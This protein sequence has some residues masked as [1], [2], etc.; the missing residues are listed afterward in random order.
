MPRHRP[1]PPRHRPV[2]VAS[3]RRQDRCAAREGVVKIR[4]SA[5]RRELNRRWNP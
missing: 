5:P 1:S 2:S 4:V 3:A